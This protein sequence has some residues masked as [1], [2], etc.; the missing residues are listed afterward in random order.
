MLYLYV[1]KIED[2]W[3]RKKMLADPETMSYNKN[4]EV[5]YDGYDKATG[6]IDFKEEEFESWLEYWTDKQP[7]RF[8]AY[9]CKD[10]GEFIGEVNFQYNEEKKWHDMGVVIYS[11]HRGKGYGTKAL[12]LLLKQAFEVCKIERIHN[13][14]SIERAEISAW[15]AHFSAGFKEYNMNENILEVM[16]TKESWGKNEN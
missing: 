7:T 15:K 9:V 2:L 3:F 4:W 13:D 6:C 1:P 8:Y 11:K 10:D 5:D 16:I 12:K 14:F